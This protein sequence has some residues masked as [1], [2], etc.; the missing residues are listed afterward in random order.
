[1]LESKGSKSSLLKDGV[2][3]TGL[4]SAGTGTNGEE[5][6]VFHIAELAVH[7]FFYEVEAVFNLFFQQGN[8]L[9]LADFVIFVADVG[10]DGEARRYWH[11]DKVHFGQVGT[12][13]TQ[14]V[15]HVGTTF[16]L[17]VTKRVNS[18]YVVHG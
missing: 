2:H 17:T 6:R 14:L 11:T 1:M 12:F 3:H 5:E 13:A 4:G 16:S 10:S 15:A 8:N 7:Q 18:F 9:V